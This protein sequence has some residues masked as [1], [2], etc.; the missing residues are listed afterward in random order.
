[1]ASHTVIEMPSLPDTVNEEVQTDGLLMENQ[2]KP[3]SKWQW[4]KDCWTPIRNSRFVRVL[5][6]LLRLFLAVFVIVDN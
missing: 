3:S 5:Q 6:T 4:I 2:P 1:M